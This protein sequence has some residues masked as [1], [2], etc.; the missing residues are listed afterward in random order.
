L[1]IERGREHTSVSTLRTVV[2]NTGVLLFAEVLSRLLSVIYLAILARYVQAVGVGKLSTAQA[3]TFSLVV[4]VN[5]GFSQLIIRDVA[6]EEGQAAAYVSNVA[7]IRSL[8]CLIYAI[9]L[10]V[11]VSILNY[12]HELAVIIYTYGIAAILG[13]FADIALSVFQ[14]FQRMEY[15][16]VLRVFRDTVNTVLSL[17]VI[18]LGYGLVVIVAVSA[19]ASLL[20]LLLGLVL[21]RRRLGVLW[22]G[23]DL[24]LSK[25]ILRA[26]VPFALIALYPLARSQL[27]TLILSSTGSLADVGWFFGANT[28]VGMLMLL[29]TI[30]MQAMFPVFSRFFSHSRTALQTSYEKSFV[31]LLVLGAAISVGTLLIADKIIPL[32]LGPGFEA[33]VPALRILAWLPLVSFVG[34]CNGDLLCAI[35]KERLFMVTEGLFAVVYAILGFILTPGFGYIGACLA[36]L[37]P[38]VVGFAFYSALCHSLLNLALPWKTVTK[39]VLAVSSMGVCTQFAL[40]R[41]VNLFVVVLCI[42]P[43][44]YGGALYFLRVF[45]HEDV[46]LFKQALRLA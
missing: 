39:V 44:V 41:G 20:Q 29:P 27:N 17:L 18:Y 35:G 24:N 5:F 37:T 22:L 34:Y 19:F 26:A 6:K 32:L 38:T 7:F 25:Q 28:V 33:A 10:Y 40:L 31:F 43:A 16:L 30:Y 1:R 8:L 21:L 13:G 23:V 42:A 11:I 2:R 46:T 4:M 9:L 36:I 14:A 12:P 3:L 45:S 15:N